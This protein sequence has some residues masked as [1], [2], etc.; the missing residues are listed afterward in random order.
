MTLSQIVPENIEG[1]FGVETR[2]DA[3][4]FYK[5]SYFQNMGEDERDRFKRVLTNMTH[6]QRYK[7]NKFITDSDFFAYKPITI[8]GGP[9]M[10]KDD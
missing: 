1:I 7:L 10:W 8:I 6:L 4:S 2:V 9:S 3:E 5:M